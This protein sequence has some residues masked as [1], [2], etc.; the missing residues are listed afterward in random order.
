[1]TASLGVGKTRINEEAAQH[2][3]QMC[4]NM[5]A[6]E[7]AVV[8]KNVDELSKYSNQ[9]TEGTLYFCRYVYNTCDFIFY[10][11]FWVLLFLYFHFCRIKVHYVVP[12]VPSVS[13]FG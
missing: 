8:S 9:P 3:F 5:D 12:L 11:K 13:D 7:V 6:S 1:M 2:V 4:A 10:H